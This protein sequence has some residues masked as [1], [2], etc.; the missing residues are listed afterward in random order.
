MRTI[1]WLV[2]FA[3]FLRADALYDPRL[4]DNGWEI[5]H[6]NY[7]DQPYVV[8][9]NDGDWLC[10]LTTGIGKEGQNRQHIVSTRSH[11]HGKTWSP[12]V[13]I[14]PA[15]GPEASWVMPL[16][17]PSGRVYVFYNYNRD[18]IR[19]LPNVNNETL[20]HRV[21][22]MGS[23]MFKFSDDTGRTW[24]KERYEIPMRKMRIDRENNANG[25]ILNF[26]GVGKPV[27]AAHYAIF[28]FAKVGRWGSPGAMVESQGC[29]LRSDNILTEKDPKK[30]RWELLPDGHVGLRA[31]KG[32]VS[33][34]ANPVVMNDGSLY[35][36]YRTIDGYNCAAYSRDDGH[37]WTPSAYAVYYPGGPMIKH[38]RAANFV[39][40]FSNGKYILWY[41]NHGGEITQTIPNWNA[42]L[43][44][45]PNW[46]SGGIEKN[47]IIYWSQPEIVLYSDDPKIGSSYPDFIEE[48]G[49]YFVTETQ[50]TIARVHEIDPTLLEGLWNQAENRTV[51][52]RGLV[53]EANGGAIEMPVLPN[54]AE[55]RGFTI[56][57]QMRLR[58]LTAGQVILDARD[59]KKGV[60][61]VT[62]DHS[63]LQLI[64]ND[65][66]KEFTWDSDSGIHP[67]TLRVNAWQ[68]VSVIVDG[69]AK[70]VSF[71]VDGILN[72]GGAIR[73][74]GWGRFPL[75]LGDVNG[76]KTVKVGANITGQVEHFRI[77]DRYLRTSEAVG[78]WRAGR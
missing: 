13:D 19:V 70:V 27:I 2:F 75:D 68:H 73:D 41:N 34:E 8:I 54:L 60:A 55:R 46:L 26:W 39:K 67:G 63:T 38:N 23:Y 32:P 4:V 12:L 57:F 9:T 47:G 31:P 14:E 24:S 51:S 33:D 64:L 56:D 1:V 49:R 7:V 78:N 11:D 22:T 20:A 17:V 59:N 28:G 71:L 74:Y 69:G 37:T 76:R 5:P 3:A 30:V 42:Y 10:V 25:E 29:F 50:K 40:K 77:Y 44:R 21:D 16:K 36:T 45:N 18:N 53:L 6:E 48:N 61:L 66:K 62:S 72:D 65:G 43:G 52:R 15:D 58:E 35:A